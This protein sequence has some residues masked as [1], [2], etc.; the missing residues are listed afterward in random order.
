MKD[1]RILDIMDF[2]ISYQIK[3]FKKPPKKQI[4]LVGKGKGLGWGMLGRL[5]PDTYSVLKRKWKREGKK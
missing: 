5:L 4:L 2:M 1:E 3:V